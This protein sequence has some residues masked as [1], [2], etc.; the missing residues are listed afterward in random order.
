MERYLSFFT[1]DYRDGMVYI[2]NKRYSAGSFTV[3]MMNRFYDND[4]CARISVF[5]MANWNVQEQLKTGYVLES[6]F[7]KAGEEIRQIHRTLGKIE[8]FNLLDLDTE[9][10][11]VEKIFTKEN[12]LR[13]ERHFASRAYI[14]ARDWGAKYHET[15]RNKIDMKEFYDDSRFIDDILMTL[16][17]YESIGDGMRD[18]FYALQEF[19]W[20]L[21]EAERFDEAHLLP[22]A[23]DC[24]KKRVEA[25]IHYVTARKNRK[26]TVAR[27]M[28]FA[29]FYSFL[30]TD[31][32]EGLHHGHYPRCCPVCGRYFLMESARKQKYCNGTAPEKSHSGKTITC[33]KYATSI[34]RKERAADDPVVAAYITRM[35]YIRKNES[36]GIFNHEYALVAKTYALACRERADLDDEYLKNGYYQDMSSKN[37]INGVNNYLKRLEEA[38]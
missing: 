4:A 10:E 30:V 16:E 2:N 20:N 19:V 29:D 25:D 1:A 31:F 21:D 26:L 36:R 22:L 6:D 11:R 24:L 5:R 28:R 9:A 23:Q 13:I 33:R 17:F 14:A 37:F 7:I 35:N 27:R 38:L 34:K 32:Y 18:A 12:A 15:Y 3:K 8:P